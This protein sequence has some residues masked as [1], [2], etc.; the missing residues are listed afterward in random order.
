MTCQ[1]PACCPDLLV[2]AWCLPAAAVHGPMFLRR[3]VPVSGSFSSGLGKIL[4]G[5][6]ARPDASTPDHLSPGGGS[7]IRHKIA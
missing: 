5:M 1:N 4:I 6:C 7:A 3:L 2:G